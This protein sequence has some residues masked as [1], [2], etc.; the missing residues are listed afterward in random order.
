METIGGAG[1]SQGHTGRGLMV[2]AA[3]ADMAGPPRRDT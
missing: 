1:G 3:Q 2:G